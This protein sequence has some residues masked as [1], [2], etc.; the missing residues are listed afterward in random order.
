MTRPD[1][2]VLRG[3][4]QGWTTILLL[5]VAAS[6]ISVL[7]S[8]PVIP[9]A[10]AQATAYPTKPVRLVVPYP[11]GGTTDLV[12]RLLSQ[13]LGSRLGQNFIV[14]NR[15]GA[16]GQI[17]TELVAKA[18]PDGYTLLV[19]ASGN[20]MMQPALSPTL[21]YNATKDFDTI[22]NIVNVPNL[23]VVSAGSKLTTLKSFIEFAKANPGKVRYASGGAGS[24]GHI[25]G[26]LFSTTTGVD[27]LHVP[28]RGGGLS[29]VSVMSGETDVNFVNL[30]TA[31]PHT[32]S[33]K[34]RGIT[35]LSTKRAATAPEFPTTVE[36]G[37]P[38]VVMTS[39]TGLLAPR[40][41]PPH[42]LNRLESALKNIAENPE[43]NKQ[44]ANLG[45]DVDFMDA[46]QYR[47][48]IRDEIK[49]FS[50]LGK[51]A[52]LSIN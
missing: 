30:P 5:A 28:Y 50:E 13:E 24:S 33:G 14:D 6:V 7:F 19:A 42:V 22:G 48:Y 11:P 44:F 26:A 15:G 10:A 45:A 29:I 17:G 49:R 35:V 47:A 38:G 9:T 32:R 39:S 23:M 12:G 4:R 43:L 52:N 18:V 2:E 51:R 41:V 21:T 3:R 31:L 37:I 1:V 8:T 25:A 46:A 34:L 20:I 27:M 40:G 16:G 36:L